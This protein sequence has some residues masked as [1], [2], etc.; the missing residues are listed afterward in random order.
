MW[1]DANMWRAW[2]HYSR[3]RQDAAERATRRMAALQGALRE[4]VTELR[5]T[6]ERH[7]RRLRRLQA[8]LWGVLEGVMDAKRRGGGG[9]K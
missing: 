6:Q 1:H 3:T 4:D 7:A 5:R 8:D 2:L 9:S